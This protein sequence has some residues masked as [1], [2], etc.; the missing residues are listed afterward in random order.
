LAILKTKFKAYYQHGPKDFW[1]LKKNNSPHFLAA[2][3]S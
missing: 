3:F 2:D 1:N